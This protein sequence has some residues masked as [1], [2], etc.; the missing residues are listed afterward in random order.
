MLGK[1]RE[2]LKLAELLAK[3]SDPRVANVAKALLLAYG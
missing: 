2:G 3:E 1:K